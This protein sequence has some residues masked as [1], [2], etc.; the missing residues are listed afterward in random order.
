[1]EEK[2]RDDD[3]KEYKGI[4]ILKNPFDE[5]HEFYEVV[6][7]Y[8]KKRQAGIQ[9]IKLLNE[10]EL[11]EEFNKKQEK[12]WENHKC[13][14]CGKKL[15]NNPYFVLCDI[16]RFKDHRKMKELI[17][18]LRKI[19]YI[20]LRKEKTDFPEFWIK[21]YDLQEIIKKYSFD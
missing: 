6:N 9:P 17:D 5:D 19:E 20:D 7:E 2:I 11:I 21:P 4:E 18:E 8:I 10:D 16:C 13:S 15:F 14:E 12:L 1:M 3:I